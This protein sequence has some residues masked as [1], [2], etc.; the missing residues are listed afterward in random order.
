[1]EKAK[2]FVV[3]DDMMNL[4]I[5]Q[6]MLNKDYEVFCLSSGEKLLELLQEKLPDLI[7]LDVHMPEMNGFDII[8]MLKGDERV[9]DIPVIFLTAD[10]D[11][12]MELK[13]FKEGALDYIVKPFVKDVMLQ[14]V[15]RVIVLNN[16]SEQ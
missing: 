4:K 8:R 13:C 10:N 15:G 16:R 7:L 2:I 12:E 11:K 1:M 5:A 14:R 9:K 6:L 3:D